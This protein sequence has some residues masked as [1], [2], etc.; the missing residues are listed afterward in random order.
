MPVPRQRPHM[1]CP[2]LRLCAALAVASLAGAAPSA[3]A[4]VSAPSLT[5]ERSVIW[6]VLLHDFSEAD[7]AGAVEAI[8]SEYE[9]STGS[10]LRPGERGKVGLKI[11]SDS[12]PG[13]STPP[14]LVKG[15][16]AALERRGFRDSDIFLVGLNQLRLRLTGFLPSLSS[17]RSTFREHPVFVLESGR[18]YESDWFYDSPLPTRF[19]PTV[20][21]R[22]TAAEAEAPDAEVDRKSFLATPLFLDAD[23]WINLPA[24]T[25]HPVLGIN[26]ALVNATL[27]NASNTQR[28]FRNPANAPAAVAEM[29]AIPELRERWALTIASL[30]RYQFI[31][32]PAFNSLYTVSEPRLWASKDPVAMDAQMLQRINSHRNRAG[33]QSLP[34]DRRLLEFSQQLGV[35]SYDTRAVIWRQLRAP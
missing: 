27:W 8:L 29:A 1:G 18:F 35:G 20:L 10:R 31:G 13:L 28:F 21:E 14:A 22:S 6:E 11:Y 3:A 26:G 16:I 33:F 5:P 12:G 24:Y 34:D 4:Q 17:G 23:F 19:D 32:G 9:A 7:Y 30:E 25:D 2:T 15:V